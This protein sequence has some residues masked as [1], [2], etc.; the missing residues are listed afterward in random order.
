LLALEA[1]DVGGQDAARF[2]GAADD[3][4]VSFVAVERGAD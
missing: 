1:G 2:S 3:K 4:N